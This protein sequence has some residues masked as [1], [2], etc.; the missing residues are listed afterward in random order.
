MSLRKSIDS[1]A[2]LPFVGLM[3]DFFL[4]HDIL[5]GDV[6]IVSGDAELMTELMSDPLVIWL[7][8][9]CEECER[10]G[11]GRLWCKDKVWGKCEECGALPVRYVRQMT[12][13]IS[14]SRVCI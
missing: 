9:W 12:E 2:V 3:S 13:T 6:V 4:K 7:Q 1:W 10:S 11:E 14:G 8:P 5:V